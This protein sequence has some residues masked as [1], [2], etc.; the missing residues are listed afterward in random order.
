MFNN[1]E[2]NSNESYKDMISYV[3]ENNKPLHLM[4]LIS[5]GGIHSHIKFILRM[6]DELHKDGVNNVLIHAITDGRDCDAHSSMKYLNMLQEKLNTYQMGKVVDICGR[7]YAMDRDKK[8]AR[9]KYYSELVT[10]GK[11]Y[12]VKNL[13]STIKLCYQKNVGDEFLPPL[14]LDRSNVIKDGDALLWLNYRPDRAKQILKVLTDPNF[15]EYE[16]VKLPN[17]KVYT[18][19][20]IKEAKNSKHLL[21]R[22]EVKN[23]LGVYLSSLG[24]SQARIAETEKYAH[25]TYFFDGGKDIKLDGCDRFLVDSPKVATYDLTPEM[26]NNEICKQVIKCINNNYDFILVN[27]ASPDMVGHTGNYGATIKALEYLDNCLSAIVESADENFYTLFITSDHGNVDVMYDEN[28]KE[29][30]THTINPVP[31]I[32]TDKKLKL[33]DGSIIDIAPTILKYMDIKIPKE[34]KD[35]NVLF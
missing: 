11:G 30:T 13:E 2:L 26:S 28:G 20:D 16:K 35:S 12:I 34:M 4:A 14:I 18:I 29:I 10:L 22:I 21:E 24:L 15:N 25:V 17:L 7:Y 19:Y 3:K 23:P 27:I 32:V 5:D 31:F 1:K 6:L 9:T 8:W 33:K